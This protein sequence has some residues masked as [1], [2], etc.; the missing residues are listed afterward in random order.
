M[1]GTGNDLKSEF[2]KGEKSEALDQQ[3]KPD[4]TPQKKPQKTKEKRKPKIYES[5]YDRCHYYDFLDMEDLSKV[6]A[7]SK[8]EL[9]NIS[10]SQAI[11]DHF[12]Y[13]NK[14]FK[15]FKYIYKSTKGDQASELTQAKKN[16]L[17]A[18]VNLTGRFKL[19]FNDEKHFTRFMDLL[20]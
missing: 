1:K 2:V 3:L 19:K 17:R 8:G 7:T 18:L 9:D 14:S 5:S 6:L 16:Y 4:G 13:S 20:N 11:K 10:K 12:S 15:L